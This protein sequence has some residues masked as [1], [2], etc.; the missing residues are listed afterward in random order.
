MMMNP[1]TNRTRPAISLTV[2]ALL[3]GGSTIAISGDDAGQAT[4][5]DGL[6]AAERVARLETGVR[7]AEGIRAAKRLQHA[8]AH[9]VEYG[10]WH[11]AADLFADRGT[12]WFGATAVT[13]REAIRA[14]MLA[15]NGG[16]PGL[17]EG[18]LNS[19]LV[20]EPVVT[21]DSD[22]SVVRGRW[23]VFGMVGQHGES[24]AW[25]GGIFENEYVEENGVWKIRTLR[26][27]PQFT[28]NYEDNGWRETPDAA[29]FHYDVT[30]AGIPVPPVRA[31]GP[32]AANARQIETRLGRIAER[33][34]RLED[35]AA[36]VN[37][38][39]SYGYYVDRK[40]WDDVVELFARDGTLEVDNR[41]VYA[42]ASMRRL[43]ETAGPQGL[44]DG[45]IHDHL[46]LQT[47]VTVADDGRTAS[48]RGVE[49]RLRG[50]NNQ[51]AEWGQAIFEN[52]YVKDGG[53][54][55]IQAM[56]IAPR[57]LAPYEQ[58]WK[59]T[60]P[61]VAQG[62]ATPDRPPTRVWALYPKVD[63][64]PFHF[65]N[66]VTGRAVQYP[67]GVPPAAAQARATRPAAPAAVPAIAELERRLARVIAYDG[68]E[69]V[70][71]AYGYYIDG[72]LWD[73]MADLFSRDG[74]KELSYIGT[75]VGRERV[76]ASVKMRY[77][78]RNGRTRGTGGFAMH[79]KT[80]PV[81]TVSEDGQS[82]RIRTRLFQLGG[83]T[84]LTGIYENGTVH[85]DGV[86]KISAMD[87]DYVWTAPYRGGW[88][89]VAGNDS[90]RF[91]PAAPP[92][93]A[94]D[95]PLR[96]VQFPPFPQVAEMAFHYRNP[97]S[98]RAPKLLLD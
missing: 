6:P 69:N 51:Y 45:E 13:G 30:R 38:Q 18:R 96:G 62:N 56:R 32:A 2:V 82:A 23:H 78:N 87:L 5:T 25:E 35:E 34:Q 70:A 71:N 9:F 19:R 11:D 58:G 54:W 8:Y 61:L 88:A 28:G 90:R 20:M 31:S 57:L 66:P 15:D 95:R 75:Y 73:D 53:V 64:V 80:Q 98:G 33:L 7:R 63:Y 16:R 27:Y 36:V 94:P 72:F 24:A 49:L 84:W 89:K 59:A 74:W 10:L 52:T 81:I 67:S 79:Q 17:P 91:A 68:T 76:R 26:E 86:W 22:G 77:G 44:A 83:S 97:V 42:G 47:Y 92:P 85:E 39:H 46:Q 1:M 37:L 40:L 55:K 12:A 29:P 41:G 50:V 93:V 4:P 3:V 21:F 48:A 14:R 60:K 65:A 43:L